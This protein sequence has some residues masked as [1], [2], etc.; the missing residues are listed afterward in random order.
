MGYANEAGLIRP[1]FIDSTGK[2]PGFRSQRELLEEVRSGTGLS[3]EK[4]RDL[5]H[6]LFQEF[7]EF[8]IKLEPGQLQASGMNGVS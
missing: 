5:Q 4:F 3:E 7:A 1:L 2:P 8:I 6:G